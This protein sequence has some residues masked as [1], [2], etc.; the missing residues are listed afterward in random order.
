MSNQMRRLSRDAYLALKGATR[1]LVESTGG[2]RFA[3]EITGFPMS[4][5]SEAQQASTMDRSMRIDHVLELE[6][7]TSDPVV[8]RE[9][10]RLQGLVLIEPPRF[11]SDDIFV[12][13]LGAVGKECGEAISKVAEAIGNG[14]TVYG[15]EIRQGHL[16]DEVDDAIEALTRLKL[17]LTHRLS[18]D[19]KPPPR[20]SRGR[21]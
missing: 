21:T 19:T 17:A 12:R 1:K 14:G 6:M 2:L 7:A 15:Y 16:I 10:A 9:L 8:T 4:K 13:H 11:D 3:A 5:I 18:T 20:K